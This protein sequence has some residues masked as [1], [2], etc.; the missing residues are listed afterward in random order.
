ME[1][2]HK[3]ETL[4]WRG[5]YGAA[6]QA[7]AEALPAVDGMDVLYAAEPDTARFTLAGA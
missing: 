5:R 6:V 2:I 4:D 7:L 1:A 3:A